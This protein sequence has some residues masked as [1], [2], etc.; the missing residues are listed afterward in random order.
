MPR[1]PHAETPPEARPARR[2]RLERRLA[3][4]WAALAW[5]RLW[6]GLWPAMGVVGVFLA[7]ALFDLPSRLPAP[8]HLA[9]LAAAASLLGWALYRFFQH[10]HLPDRN[11]ARRRIETASGLAHRPL[12]TLED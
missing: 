10:F 1:M 4:A 11:A 12:A 7:L 2:S 9:F 8:L 6:P 3:L 5:E